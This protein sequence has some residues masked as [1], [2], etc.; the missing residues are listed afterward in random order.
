MASSSEGEQNLLDI[1]SSGP[2]LDTAA[3]EN[4]ALNPGHTSPLF[5]SDRDQS[6]PPAPAPTTLPQPSNGH[7]AIVAP[8][9]ERPWEYQLYEDDTT[10]TE[11]LEEI[12]GQYEVKY[13]VKFKDGHEQTVSLDTSQ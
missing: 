7:I 11:V 10:I 4:G 3:V 9:V 13:L 12:I 1:S 5:L 6:T 8:P 2:G